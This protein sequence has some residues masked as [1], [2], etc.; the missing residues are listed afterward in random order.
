MEELIDLQGHSQLIANFL[1]DYGLSS[2]AD[3]F[4]IASKIQ[5]IGYNNF[6]YDELVGYCESA[7]DYT[8]ALGIAHKELIQELVIFNFIWNGLESLIT[9][10]DLKACPFYSGKINSATH[11]IQ[12]EFEPNALNFKYYNEVIKYLKT[13]LEGTDIIPTKAN[14]TKDL[15]SLN[16][17]NSNYGLGLTIVYK[18]RNEFAHGAFNFPTPNN[19]DKDEDTGKMKIEKLKEPTII[20]VSSRI[21]LLSIQI[22]LIGYFK[23]SDAEILINNYNSSGDE[24][25]IKYFDYLR[26]L[27]YYDFDSIDDGDQLSFEFPFS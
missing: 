25:Y 1:F 21:V 3:W 11:F 19:W 27:H 23:N 8:D 26:V 16:K 10:L 14:N 17:C 2:S 15:F 9:A 24:L 13:L 18:I 22:I 12:M 7:D 20:N 5:E 6:K 4:D